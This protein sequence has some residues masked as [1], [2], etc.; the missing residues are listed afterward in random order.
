MDD[1]VRIHFLSRF[2]LFHFLSSVYIPA[3]LQ[4]GY[5]IAERLL[6]LRHW[7]VGAAGLL[8]KYAKEV[9]DYTTVGSKQY[10]LYFA[11]NKRKKYPL[12]GIS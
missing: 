7:R 2:V 12:L 9:K 10:G 3:R 1:L 11:T 5:C 4:S 6:L 8:S